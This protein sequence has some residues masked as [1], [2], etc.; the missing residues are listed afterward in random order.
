M[1]LSISGVLILSAFV[2]SGCSTINY[3]TNAKTDFFSEP[4]INQVV[5]AYVGDYM[6]DQGKSTTMEYLTLAHLIDGVAYDIPQGSYAR[7]GDYKEIPYFSATNTQGQSIRYAAGLIDPPIALHT[8]KPNEVCVTSVSYQSA[9]CYDGQLKVEERTV[10]DN[11]SFQQTL[12]YNGSVGKKIN[13]SYRE[14]SDGSARN[15]FTNNVEY[16]M[17]KS[18]IINY[19]GARIEVLGYDNTSIKFKVLNHF[20]SDFSVNM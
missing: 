13:I 16:D 19:K 9:S 6:L 2:M 17:T 14:F 7:I 10:T 1:K 3:N 20:R 4:P 15:A 8:K 12:I 11:Q 18:N 5:E